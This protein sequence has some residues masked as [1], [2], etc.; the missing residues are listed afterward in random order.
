MFQENPSKRQ[1]TSS[2][3]MT[4][5]EEAPVTGRYWQFCIIINNIRLQ[6]EELFATSQVI[7][8]GLRVEENPEHGMKVLQGL[9]LLKKEKVLC[10]VTLIAEG[11]FHFVH[12]T[13]VID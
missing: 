5:G 8:G 1:R 2:P 7:S 11:K 3:K 10:D 12:F 4:D 6:Y 9:N 13:V